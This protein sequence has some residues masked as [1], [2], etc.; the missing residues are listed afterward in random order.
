MRNLALMWV[1]AACLLGCG[2]RDKDAKDK[3]VSAADTAAVVSDTVASVSDT[4]AVDVT[5]TVNIND[6]N[7][8]RTTQ[9]KKQFELVCFPKSS[10]NSIV[11]TGSRNKADIQRVIMQNLMSMRDVYIKRLKYDNTLCGRINVTF[12]IDEL[13]EVISAQVVESTMNDTTFENTIIMDCVKK[14]KF[15]R[16]DKPGDTTVVTYP[17]RFSY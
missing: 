14:W 15:E 8:N 7:S 13:G 9:K 4:A 6:D 16:I 10:R 5:E 3:A 17:L 1:L 2:G 11:L 12:A